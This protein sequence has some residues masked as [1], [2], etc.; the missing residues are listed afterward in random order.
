LPKAFFSPSAPPGILRH[1][2]RFCIR[3][4][5]C[6]FPLQR[7]LFDCIG[8]LVKKVRYDGLDLVIDTVPVTFKEPFGP[9]AKILELCMRGLIAHAATTTCTHVSA[10]L[11]VQIGAAWPNSP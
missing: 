3:S 10:T 8:A 2:A 9:V 1:V 7:V 11:H 6:V 4:A 5:N